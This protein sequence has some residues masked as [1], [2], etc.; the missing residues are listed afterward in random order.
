[1]EK[2]QYD[3]IFVLG[4]KYMDHPL[5]GVAILRRLL[6][7]QGYTCA[8]VETPQKAQDVLKFGKPKLFFGVSS[9]GI[10]S[11]VRNYTALNRKREDDELL[12]YQ[13]KIPDRA[14][15]VY[16]NWI[17]E[18]VKDS[19]IIIGGTE[20]G[21]RRFTHYDY[22]QNSLRKSILLILEQTY[23]FMVMGKSKY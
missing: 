14:V 2:T 10:D 11:M 5:C 1:M 9:G 15:I 18:M 8:V 21:L 19:K 23:W 13:Q 17:K 20:A 22:W 7:K 4:E 3:V 12:K 6:E 16:C